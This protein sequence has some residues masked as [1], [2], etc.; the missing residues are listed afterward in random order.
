MNAEHPS[1]E[2]LQR[3]FDGDLPRGEAEVVRAHVGGCA[4]CQRELDA[5]SRVGELMRVSAE[6]DAA[7][8]DFSNLFA[9]IES[10]LDTD[11]EARDVVTPLR[12]AG[13]ARSRPITSPRLKRLYRAAPALGA[14]ALAAAALLMVYRPDQSG[15][16]DE[17]PYE[18][19]TASAHSEVVDVDFGPNAGTVF[20]ISLS[21]GSSIPVVWIDDDDDEE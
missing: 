5:L 6:H 21:D 3:S 12:A 4:H 18:A 16:L 19:V 1:T 14:I 8:A 10:A 20:D 9:Q 2:R 15:D 17:T 13:P 11:S 7:Q